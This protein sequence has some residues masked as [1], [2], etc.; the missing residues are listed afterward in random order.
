MCL[1]DRLREIWWQRVIKNNLISKEIAVN[2]KTLKPEDAIG[3]PQR[4]DYPLLKGKEVMIQAEID[5]AVG[6]AFTDKPSEFRGNLFKLH[7]MEINTNANRA[8]LVAGINATYRLLNL[9]KATRHC[10]NDGPEKCAEKISEYLYN[11]YG[12][13]KL[14]VIGFQP[15]IVYYLSKEFSNIR[16]TDM[17]N[18]NIG[19]KYYKVTIESYLKNREVIRWSDIILATGSSLVNNTIENI[20]NWAG[21]KPL[22]FYGVTIAAAAYEFKL[23]RLCFNSL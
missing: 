11:L 4:K 21:K 15:A 7:K 18:E 10:T 1:L 20:L 5:G 9:V 12:N 14:C 19:R 22:Y 16:V 6:Q 13:V 8:I 2:I 3:Q 17:D 23:K